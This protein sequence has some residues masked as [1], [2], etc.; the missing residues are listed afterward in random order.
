[1]AQNESQKECFVLIVKRGNEEKYVA[2]KYY[3]KHHLNCSI[4]P[5]IAMKF[6]KEK[7]AYDFWE[8][9]KDFDK[10]L[11]FVGVKKMVVTYKIMEVTK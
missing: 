4:K 2:K 1:M 5:D 10:E 6:N 11:S 8:N 7:N 3:S 9:W